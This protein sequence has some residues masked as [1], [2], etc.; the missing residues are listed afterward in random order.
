MMPI[1]AKATTQE[2]AVSM[3]IMRVVLAS[4]PNLGKAASMLIAPAS[5]ASLS[6]SRHRLSMH[7]VTNAPSWKS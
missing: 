7:P 5:N 2:V 3:L 1:Q 6:G 4:D